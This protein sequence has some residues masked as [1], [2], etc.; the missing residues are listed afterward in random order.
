ML[1]V[2]ILGDLE[3]AAILSGTGN[4]VLGFRILD[5]FNGG[6]FA[7]LASLSTVIVAIS[8]IVVILALA[9]GRRKSRF[10]SSMNVG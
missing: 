8:A 6:S 2:R 4:P 7:L 1:F 3:V 9:Y 5:V 10:G